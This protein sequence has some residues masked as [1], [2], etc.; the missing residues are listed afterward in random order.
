MN[1]LPN[2]SSLN[3]VSS[4]YVPSAV[5]K[6]LGLLSA[7][8]TSIDG[9]VGMGTQISSSLLVGIA[10]HELTHAMG[11]EPGV[12]SFDLFC[13]TS[14]GNHLF[15]SS[16]TAPA[17][18]LSIDGGYTKLADFGRTSDPSDFLNTGVQGANDSFDEFYSSGTIQNLTAV[19]KELLDVLGF[20]TTGPVATNTAV[21]PE[22]FSHYKLFSYNG[23]VAVL[24]SDGGDRLQG[25]ENIQFADQ[26]V[27]VNTVP[28]FD[29]Y[30]YIAS[31]HDLI[32]A[33]GA[34]GEAGFD[35]YIDYGL[36]EG[37]S[38]NLFDGLEYIASNPDLIKAFGANA[39]AGAQHYDAYG[40]N[41]GRAT[42]S[43]RWN[44]LR[45]TPT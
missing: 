8:G 41:E 16:N 14:P 9:A 22:A 40:F 43:T 19:D 25:I 29:A 37:R 28:A 38:L 26:T 31:N 30:E 3:G 5:D 27:S 39:E 33:F 13:Y 24:S 45:R 12:G 15:S 17:A 18:Y 23:I 10:L 42:H 4:F 32:K 6:A 7:N 35:H 21:Y 20:N 36:S 34:N 44:I 11:G 2:T 1:S